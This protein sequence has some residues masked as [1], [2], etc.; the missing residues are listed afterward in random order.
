MKKA[1]REAEFGDKAK[2]KTRID[3]YLAEAI[4]GIDNKFILEGYNEIKNM[5]VSDN[6]YWCK[7]GSICF[8][9]ED[10][11]SALLALK[12]SVEKEKVNLNYV[13]KGIITCELELGLEEQI[14]EDC[15]NGMEA[16]LKEIGYDGGYT[17]DVA[18]GYV[19]SYEFNPRAPKVVDDLEF[20]LVIYERYHKDFDYSPK[21]IEVDFQNKKRI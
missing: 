12:Y 13:Y 1:I 18:Q 17:V 8:G 5:N 15:V 3:K 14:S 19:D 16:L 2:V 21:F 11:C 9:V 4:S 6:N 10:Y 7:V 20:L